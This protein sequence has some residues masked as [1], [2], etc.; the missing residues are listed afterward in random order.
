MCEDFSASADESSSTIKLQLVGTPN[1]GPDKACPAMAKE[2]TVTVT[3]AS[4]WDKRELVD[5]A[6]GQR[7]PLS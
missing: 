1:Q 5:A 4:P 7:V 6:T 2:V 3:L